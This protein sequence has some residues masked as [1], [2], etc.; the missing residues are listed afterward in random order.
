MG[1]GTT[2]GRRA[3]VVGGASG[4]GRETCRRLADA[5]WVVTVADLQGEAAGRVAEELRGGGD[6][7]HAHRAVDVTDEDSVRALFDGAGE[8]D[9]VVTTAGT[10]TL[11]PVVEHD[12]A[13][14]R[15][16]VDVCLTGA[17][18]VFKHGGPVVRAGGAM[19]A[20][21]SL[22]ARQAGVGM[23]AYCAAKAGLVMLA[24]VT[25]L[26]LGPR[27]VRVNTVSPGYVPT[28]LTEAVAQI[29]GLEADYLDNTPLGR[30]GTT[31]DVADAICFAAGAPW[32]TGE[33]I[34]VNGG[35]HLGR[36]PDILAR[37]TEAYS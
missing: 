26:E 30:V 13:Q 3:V 14:W 6:A 5:G 15:H 22:N 8:L 23:A 24:Q 34:D 31:G 4:I 20:V 29:P 2:G 32:L 37:A 21:A 19:V 10:S 9:L 27:G 11:G 18:L 36:Y 35:A 12:T 1:N 28:P 25:A 7:G 16:V 17:F 33:N